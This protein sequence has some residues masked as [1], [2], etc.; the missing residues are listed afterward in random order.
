MADYSGNLLKPAALL[1]KKKSYEYKRGDYLDLETG[2]NYD[3]KDSYDIGD[4]MI[5]EEPGKMLCFQSVF[6]GTY[7]QT[8]LEKGKILEKYRSK[9]IKK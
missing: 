1:Y 2:I 3:S 7:N 5:C 6:S 8:Y 9:V 4:Y